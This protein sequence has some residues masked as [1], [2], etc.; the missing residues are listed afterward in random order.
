MVL[1]DKFAYRFFQ[2]F[3]VKPRFVL[4]ED[5][6]RSKTFFGVFNLNLERHHTSADRQIRLNNCH[7]LHYSAAR[8]WL[9]VIKRLIWV[10]IEIPTV[11]STVLDPGVYLLTKGLLRNTSI[12]TT[13]LK[14]NLQYYI[15]LCTCHDLPALNSSPERTS[16][17]NNLE[18]RWPSF[19]SRQESEPF[20]AVTTKRLLFYYLQRLPIAASTRGEGHRFVI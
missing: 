20:F 1:V 13:G 10:A 7:C 15:T 16:D 12:L 3:V 18:F 8:Y 4:L 14:K 9:S 17:Y 2:I 11:S 6:Q 5:R 19:G